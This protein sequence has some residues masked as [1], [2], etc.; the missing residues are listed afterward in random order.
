MT[1]L[2]LQ[3]DRLDPGIP[4]RTLAPLS[5]T[6][7]AGEC[8][9]IL[10]PN[11]A[12]KTTLLHTLA[13]LRSPV[14][15][16]IWLDGR[17]LSQW[18]RQALAQRRAVVFQTQQDSFPTTVR[19]A[20]LLG[21]YPWRAGWQGETDAD[22]HR[23]DQALAALSLTALAQRPLEQLSGGERQRVA[24][25]VADAL[26]PALWLVDEP[27]NHLD[28]HHQVQVMRRLSHHAQAGAAVVMC[29]HDVNL[30]ARWCDRVL[31]LGTDGQHQAGDAAT[32]LT[33]PRL[34]ALYGE[35]LSRAWLAGAPVFVPTAVAGLDAA[36]APAV[37]PPD[38]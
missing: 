1:A 27:T 21:R 4:G 15:G 31:L 33:E 26:A 28:L 12:G 22:H 20:V 35:P 19:E 37:E 8:W 25:A 11:G 3:L 30:A 14:A 5:L 24:L 29:L 36:A 18:P 9:G 2:V 16:Q 34:S 17:R 38:A 7:Q 10:G 32:L 13:G 6:I 23:V